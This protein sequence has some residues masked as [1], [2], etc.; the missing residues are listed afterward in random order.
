MV[1]SCLSVFSWRGR[2]RLSAVG[3]EVAQTIYVFV[4][5]VMSKRQLVGCIQDARLGY[6]EVQKVKKLCC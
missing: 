3:E 5:R 4:I 1:L 6:F 2:D